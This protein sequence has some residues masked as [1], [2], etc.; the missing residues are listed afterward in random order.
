MNAFD[1][2]S[3][4]LER[5]QS[6]VDIH[7]AAFPKGRPPKTGEPADVLRAVVV[8][9]VAAVDSYIHDKITENAVR[10]VVCCSKKGSG[11]PGHLIDV[12]KPAITTEKALTL[13]YRKRPD[14]EIQKIMRQHLSERT[15]QDPGKIEGAMR[16]LGLSDM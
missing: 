1:A 7:S 10:I 15:F 13:I 14:Q 5:A 6:L 8:F 3:K 16:Y 2:F 11:F 12:M 4:T 9:A